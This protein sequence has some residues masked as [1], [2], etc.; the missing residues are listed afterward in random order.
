MT[1]PIIVDVPH[2]LGKAEARARVDRGIGKLADLFPGGA[3]VE[4]H[5]E[6]DALAFTVSALGQSVDCRLEVEEA[7]VRA[8]VN[9]PP[10]LALFAEKLR[11]KLAREAPK[12]LE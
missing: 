5:W 8:I 2:R 3:A 4:H 6:G 10:F 12:L 7:R 11:A 1:D 9:L